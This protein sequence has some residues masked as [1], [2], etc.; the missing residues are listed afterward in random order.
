M[1]R[2]EA[3]NQLVHFY[4]S[5]P[6]GASSQHKMDMLLSYIERLGML[7]PEIKNPL[8]KQNNAIVWAQERFLDDQYNRSPR[9]PEEYYVNEWEPETNT[10][11][12][13]GIETGIGA[14]SARCEDCWNDRFGD[15]NE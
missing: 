6:D 2:S 14:G 4:E 1:K 7:P 5:I 13:C 10:C 11:K 9:V 3:I 8:V 15:Y 12:D